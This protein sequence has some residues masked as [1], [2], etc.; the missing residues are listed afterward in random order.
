MFDSELEPWLPEPA[1]QIVLNEI[2]EGASTTE[3]RVLYNTSGKAMDIMSERCKEIGE[4]LYIDKYRL[5]EQ[6]CKQPDLMTMACTLSGFARAWQSYLNS[7]QKM[8][9]AAVSRRYREKWESH[10]IK[11]TEAR[12]S[13]VAA[14]EPVCYRIANMR[15][16]WEYWMTLAEGLR[17]SISQ[18][19]SMLTRLV[20]LWEKE[21][22][23]KD[24]A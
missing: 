9:N 14:S 6:L 21:Y 8:T 17:E 10:K 1:M 12:L 23:V 19:G 5:D 22:F 15:Q 20:V 11:F 2:Q 7:L 13:S 4:S 16:E 24:S 18:K 3:I